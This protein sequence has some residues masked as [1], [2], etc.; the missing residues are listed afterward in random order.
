MNSPEVNL[1]DQQLNFAALGADDPVRH[2]M[3][4]WGVGVGYHAA[5]SSIYTPMDLSTLFDLA[6]QSI[7]H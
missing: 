5:Y 2:R 6:M 7:Y 3:D 1:G 4:T